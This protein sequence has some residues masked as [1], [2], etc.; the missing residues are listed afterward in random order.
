MEPRPQPIGTPNR[1][2]G[3]FSPGDVVCYQNAIPKGRW[4]RNWL[5][6][7]GQGIV[8]G[9]RERGHQGCGYWF[10]SVQVTLP[11]DRWSQASQV[12]R[13]IYQAKG[14]RLLRSAS[15]KHGGWP[16]PPLSEIEGLRASEV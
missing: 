4:Y 3:P 2:D 14:L 9:C 15:T 12:K 5:E 6:E 13:G 1:D 10:C 16:V 8:L 7:A 11:A